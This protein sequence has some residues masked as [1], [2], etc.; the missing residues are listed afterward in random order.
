M[1]VVRFRENG[2]YYARSLKTVNTM[3]LRDK[4]T[5]FIYFDERL[6]GN[7]DYTGFL[8]RW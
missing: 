5:Q 3:C 6:V 8:Y 2:W 4:F 1:Y 7:K